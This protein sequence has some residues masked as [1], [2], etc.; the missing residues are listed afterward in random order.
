MQFDY[1]PILKANKPKNKEVL[2]YIVGMGIA[3]LLVTLA[4]YSL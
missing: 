3:V 2:A 1:L 4:F